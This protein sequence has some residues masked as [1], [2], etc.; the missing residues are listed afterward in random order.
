M[1][2]IGDK[3]F[4]SGPGKYRTVRRDG[5]PIRGQIWRLV[6][7]ARLARY[8]AEAPGEMGPSPGLVSIVSIT[9]TQWSVITYLAK[10]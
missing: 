5:H 1:E 9:L 2:Q 3:K 8:R 4:P 7:N 6:K 10:M